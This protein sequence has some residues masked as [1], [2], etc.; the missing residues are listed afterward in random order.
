MRVNQARCYHLGPQ[1]FDACRNLHLSRRPNL[2]NLA[3][4]D[5]H[6]AVANRLTGHR[7][8]CLSLD[9]ELLTRSSRCSEQ[10]DPRNHTNQHKKS[11]LISCK[12]V[13]RFTAYCSEC[14]HFS[15]S[16]L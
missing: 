1:C 11:S 8:N 2:L 4:S 3:V 6:D 16:A 10:T 14:A 13:D 9:G 5:Q 15:L 7:K 12:F